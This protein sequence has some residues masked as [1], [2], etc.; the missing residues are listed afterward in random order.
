MSEQRRRSTST[1]TLWDDGQIIEACRLR[2]DLPKKEIARLLKFDI[3]KVYRALRRAATIAAE[4]ERRHQWH[5]RASEG[6]TEQIAKK[7]Q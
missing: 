5:E 7:C 3:H 1:K 6:I 4:L 2:P